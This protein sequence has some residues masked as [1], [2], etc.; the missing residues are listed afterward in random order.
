MIITWMNERHIIDV[1]RETG[2]VAI[3][4][5]IVFLCERV[6]IADL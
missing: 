4:L 5:G 6:E 3:W 2:D 1:R